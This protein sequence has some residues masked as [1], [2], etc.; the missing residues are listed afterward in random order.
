M[1][2]LRTLARA[3]EIE[4]FAQK[5]SHEK[6]A[7]DNTDTRKKPQEIQR[8]SSEASEQTKS[9]TTK[10]KRHS[11]QDLSE[12]TNMTQRA[13]NLNCGG[14]GGKGKARTSDI[15][16]ISYFILLDNQTRYHY[17]EIKGG[18]TDQVE[19]Y[20]RGGRTPRVEGPEG[21]GDALLRLPE[22]RRQGGGGRDR[23]RATEA[24][25]SFGF[26]NR[27]EVVGETEPVRTSR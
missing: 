6:H 2:V 13:H 20:P 26:E 1:H 15:V 3:F 19:K 4:S 25:F 27:M 10:K 14:G 18:K 24:W 22:H 11:A 9:T 5:H 23:R 12:Q 7:G 16:R 8:T 21:P 17:Q